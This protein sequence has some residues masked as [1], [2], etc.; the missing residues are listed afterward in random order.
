MKQIKNNKIKKAAVRQPRKSKE[1]N[2]QAHYLAIE[3]L[4]T[5]FIEGILIGSA[6]AADWQAGT[7]LLD[8]SS[9]IAETSQDTLIFFEPVIEVAQ[10]VND[11]YQQSAT[12]MTKLLDLSDLGPE[13]SIAPEGVAEFYNQ[14]ATQMADLLDFSKVTTWPAI[15]SGISI[16]HN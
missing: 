12:E 9:G 7:A 3:I 8:M 1:K 4:A 6:H 11:F 16:E 2:Y 14:V 15:V 5:L 13:L 10:G